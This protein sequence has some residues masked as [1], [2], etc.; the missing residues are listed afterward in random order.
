[1]R[2]TALTIAMSA[3]LLAAPGAHAQDARKSFTAQGP[4]EKAACDAANKQ[5]KDW[6]KQ[7]KSQ[8]RARELLDDGKCTCTAAGGAQACTL[9][10]AVRDEQH[11]DEEER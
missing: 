8:G 5:A 6:T 3:V 2:F 11:E 9:D 1:M 7:G 4:T 10:V